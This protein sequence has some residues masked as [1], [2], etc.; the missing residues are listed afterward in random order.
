MAEMTDKTSQKN[1][2]KQDREC[3]YNI[4]LRR[5]HVTI[6]NGNVTMRSAADELY[7]SINNMDFG[8]FSSPE[9]KNITMSS[10]SR[11]FFFVIITK[12]VFSRKIF[13][14]TAPKPNYT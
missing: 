4:K 10:S 14:K 8:E 3:T 7:V 13:N 6:F 2:A 11:Y 9:A 5:V 12:F 1:L